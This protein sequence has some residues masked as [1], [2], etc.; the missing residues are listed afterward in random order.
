MS[1]LEGTVFTVVTDH[2]A[3]QWL[4]NCPDPLGRLA[5]WCLTLQEFDFNI[6]HRPGKQ[7]LV[8]D[9]LSRNPTLVAMEPTGVL[10][11]HALIYSL[12][13]RTSCFGI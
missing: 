13:P 4:M 2:D 7:N 5:R 9:A 12:N 10:P 8:P 11:D 3:L 6:V 1:G